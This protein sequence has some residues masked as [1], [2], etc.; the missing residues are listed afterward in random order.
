MTLRFAL[1]LALMPALSACTTPPMAMAEAEAQCARAVRGG[2]GSAGF[3]TLG[4][5]GAV[6]NT[7]VGLITDLPQYPRDPVASYNACVGRKTGLAPYTR[8]ADRPEMRG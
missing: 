5:G 3:V 2:G 4:L 1:C 6:G 7:G 8:L